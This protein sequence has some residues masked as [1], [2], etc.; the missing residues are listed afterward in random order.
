[1]YVARIRFNNDAQQ[2]KF[3]LKNGRENCTETRLLAKKKAFGE[4]RT[5]QSISFIYCGF[6]SKYSNKKH[7]RKGIF[8]SEI[9]DIVI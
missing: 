1:M 4:K 2:M 6:S 7:W 9:Y 8:Q 5:E 3:L